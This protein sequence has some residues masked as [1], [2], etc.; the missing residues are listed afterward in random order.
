MH[1]EEEDGSFCKKLYKEEKEKEL[2]WTR[3]SEN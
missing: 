2:I 3:C 1:E